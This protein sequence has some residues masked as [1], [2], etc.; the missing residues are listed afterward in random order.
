MDEW[1]CVVHKC[2]S[3]AFSACSWILFEGTFSGQNDTN[4]FTCQMNMEFLHFHHN[5]CVKCFNAFL[6]VKFP[7]WCSYC[8]VYSNE[9]CW[10]HLSLY[11]SFYLI[12]LLFF[13]FFCFSFGLFVETLI[14][15][16]L[17]LFI[18]YFHNINI[19]FLFEFLSNQLVFVFKSMPLS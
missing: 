9:I 15:I 19:Y 10:F 16:Y 12:C 13:L 5:F 4:P 8:Y 14:E 17:N 3:H 1:L 7:Y 6:A 18:T 11:F 2:A